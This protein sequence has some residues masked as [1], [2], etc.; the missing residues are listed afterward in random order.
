M[1]EPNV[2]T[3]AIDQVAPIEDYAKGSPSS[4]SSPVHAAPE[5]VGMT[6][7]DEIEEGRTGMFAYLKTRNFYIV[8][9]LGYIYTYHTIIYQGEC[10]AKAPLQTGPGSLHHR[11]E[12]LLQSAIGDTI[13]DPC[14][15]DSLELHSPEHNLYVLHAL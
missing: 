12:H 14:I 8:L 15:P 11:H 4:S 13:F 3:T 6:T 10:S 7:A 9:L 1:V 2:K 5:V